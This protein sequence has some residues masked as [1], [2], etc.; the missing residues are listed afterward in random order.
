MVLSFCWCPYAPPPACVRCSERKQCKSV[1]WEMLVMDM[2]PEMTDCCGRCHESMGKG[3]QKYRLSWKSTAGAMHSTEGQCLEVE[4]EM[5]KGKVGQLAD[6]IKFRP[7]NRTSEEHWGSVVQHGNYTQNTFCRECSNTSLQ[8]NIA[9]N[10]EMKQNWGPVSFFPASRRGST[11]HQECNPATLLSCCCFGRE[12]RISR[13]ELEKGPVLY[14]QICRENS[15]GH[16]SGAISY[17][18]ILSENLARQTRETVN[19]SASWMLA[20][21]DDGCGPGCEGHRGGPV[22]GHADMDEVIQKT[23]LL[24]FFVNNVFGREGCKKVQ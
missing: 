4:R 15:P 23:A 9:A 10:R 5:V 8:K 19:K 12:Q 17:A 13:E 3:T 16:R 2:E 14:S 24:K 21:G 22:K 18:E 7:R 6:N 1:K 20:R 11:T